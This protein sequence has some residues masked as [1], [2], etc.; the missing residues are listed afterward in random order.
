ML[1]LP[2]RDHSYLRLVSTRTG[3]TLIEVKMI[4]GAVI[5]WGQHYRPSEFDARLSAD[6]DAV[7]LEGTL[8]DRCGTVVTFGERTTIRASYR[9][10][11]GTLPPDFAAGWR[12]DES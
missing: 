8:C 10:D 12:R 9:I 4:D 2:Y 11:V 1:S 5:V 7:T 6:G 3:E